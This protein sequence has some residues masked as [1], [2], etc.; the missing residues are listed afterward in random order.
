MFSK[1]TRG[2][3]SCH[4]L[5]LL[6]FHPFRPHC[7]VQTDRLPLSLII[8]PFDLFHRERTPCPKK[9][10]PLSSHPVACVKPFRSNYCV[11]QLA[12]NGFTHVFTH[13]QHFHL[14]SHSLF[15]RC[16]YA[17]DTLNLWLNYFRLKSDSWYSRFAAKNR[18]A[19]CG[20]EIIRQKSRAARG[21]S[22]SSLEAASG[23]SILSRNSTLL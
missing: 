8:G 16:Q 20:F 21:L 12:A 1:P 22:S 10:K 19:A 18:E 17:V 6:P 14:K 3:S 13:Y 15:I 5:L 9:A 7:C 2:S 11:P 23:F 4:P